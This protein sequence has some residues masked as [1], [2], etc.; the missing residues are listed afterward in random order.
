MLIY[1]KYTETDKL[2]PNENHDNIPLKNTIIHCSMHFNDKSSCTSSFLLDSNFC[3][4]TIKL[5]TSSF[6]YCSQ[7]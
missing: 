7:N 5:K 2:P 3:R 1:T 4:L 6:S